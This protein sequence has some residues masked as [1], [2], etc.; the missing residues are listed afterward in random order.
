MSRLD[1]SQATLDLAERARGRLERPLG[2]RQARV[3]MDM[4]TSSGWTLVGWHADTRRVLERLEALGL[5]RFAGHGGMHRGRE[6]PRYVATPE[7][8]AL[9][10]V[11]NQ[12]DLEDAERFRQ[13]LRAGRAA[14]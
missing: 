10:V 8:R 7:G 12:E 3:L 2:S 5:A 6:C 14:R 1:L 11:M 9:G 4:A 13:E